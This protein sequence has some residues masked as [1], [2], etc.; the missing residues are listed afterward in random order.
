MRTKKAE[1]R[2]QNIISLI[3]AGFFISFLLWLFGVFEGNTPT[4]AE[5][6]Y[7][8][9]F[10][11]LT[12]QQKKET[13]EFFVNRKGPWRK[14]NINANSRIRKMAK[15]RLKHPSSYQIKGPIS[16]SAYNDH[17]IKYG[18]YSVNEDDL[19]IYGKGSYKAKTDF[20]NYKR[21]KYQ[22]TGKLSNTSFVIT[23]FEMD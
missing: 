12:E 19:L 23:S 16:W 22:V 7:K 14:L 3:I 17:F 6:L 9:R 10:S 8:Q 5:S 18:I 2:A 20:N 21:G 1:I 13:V 11:N 4:K 15:S